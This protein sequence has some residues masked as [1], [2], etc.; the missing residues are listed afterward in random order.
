MDL[1]NSKVILY[2]DGIIVG[3]YRYEIN[4]RTRDLHIEDFSIEDMC[5]GKGY[6]SYLGRTIIVLAKLYHCKT[7]SLVDGSSLEGFWQRLGYKD[8]RGKSISRVKIE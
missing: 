6:G 2:E 7:S 5:R 1:V 8:V 4:R 3:E